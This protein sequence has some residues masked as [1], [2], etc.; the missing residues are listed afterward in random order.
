MVNRTPHQTCHMHLCS[1]VREF[2]LIPRIAASLTSPI[3]SRAVDG[4]V[5]PIVSVNRC[6]SLVVFLISCVSFAQI[7]LV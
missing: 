2:D 3:L 1:Q 5:T 6:E 7:A 4:R